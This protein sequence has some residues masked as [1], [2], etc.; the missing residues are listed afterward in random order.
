M[1][2]FEGVKR[3][4]L[5][6]CED[7]HVGL[8]TVIGYVEDEMPEASPM[9]IRLETLNLLHELLSAGQI[10]AGF[11]DSNGRDFH[12][13]PF[14]AD[15]IIDTIKSLWKATGPRPKPGEIVWFTT[16]SSASVQA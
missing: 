14:P 15:A 1:A 2:D 4:L 13:W 11:P 3:D 6:E 7:D 10:Q 12:P 16:P 9:R 5:A 8:W